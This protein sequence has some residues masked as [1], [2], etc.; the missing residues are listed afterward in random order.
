MEIIWCMNGCNLNL[1]FNILRIVIW[2]MIKVI[3]AQ[4]MNQNCVW[5]Q[6]KTNKNWLA[7]LFKFIIVGAKILRSFDGFIHIRNWVFWNMDGSRFLGNC[8]M[9]L[10]I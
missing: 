9:N 4:N 1:T 10:D 7:K 2:N 3:F 6:L 8:N 5:V